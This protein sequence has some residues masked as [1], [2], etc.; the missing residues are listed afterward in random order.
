MQVSPRTVDVPVP[1][2]GCLHPG[3]PCPV[4]QIVE[5]VVQVPVPIHKKVVHHVQVV[6]KIVGPYPVERIVEQ[7]VPYPVQ[8]I[9]DRPIPYPVQKIVERPEWR[10][11]LR[12]P[13]HRVAS[14]E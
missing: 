3:Y 13:N 6:Q 14:L 5:K 8:R 9:V 7:R 12:F 4:E 11:S 1:H 2:E 10:R